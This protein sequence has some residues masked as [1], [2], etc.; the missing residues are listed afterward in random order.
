MR[1]SSTRMWI[2]LAFMELRYYPASLCNTHMRST[3]Q[4]EK[5]EG[6]MHLTAVSVER[7]APQA[8][9]AKM[10]RLQAARSQNDAGCARSNAAP[11]RGSCTRH[12]R[13]NAACQRHVPALAAQRKP[14][15]V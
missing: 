5:R 8:T 11:L 2:V 10:V 15:L 7:R 6:G 14:V 1:S 4:V 13:R 9:P 12:D 3:A